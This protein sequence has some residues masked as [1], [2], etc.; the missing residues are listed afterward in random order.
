MAQIVYTLGPMYLYREYFKAKVLPKY[1]IL[2]YRDPEGSVVGGKFSSRN[3]LY[4]EPAMARPYIQQ[5]SVA[6]L[7]FT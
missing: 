2:G 1:V 5:S 7:R 4:V 6:T 3:T